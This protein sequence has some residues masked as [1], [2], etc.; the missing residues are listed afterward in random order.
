M[1][2]SIR[3]DDGTNPPATST[4]NDNSFLSTAHTLSNFDD[5]GVLAH[6]WSLVD[7]PIGSSASLSALDTA[8]TQLTPDVAG[9][10]L[11][12][13]ETYLDA[14]ATTL[15]GV[16]EQIVGV[17][18]PVPYDWLIPAAGETTQ[19]SS[20]R[21]WAQSREEAVREAHAFMNSGIPQLMGVMNQ[22]LDGADPET[23]FGGFVLDPT[24][25]PATS[26]VLRVLGSITVAGAGDGVLRLYDLGAV[27]DPPAAGILRAEVTIENAAA[28]GVIVRDAKLVPVAA[29]GVN[30]QQIETAR[31]RY[32]L[33]AELVGG[34][35][36]DEFRI[37]QGAIAVEG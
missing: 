15:D 17:R 21:G 27:G 37:L 30:V 25:F 5:T 14:S 16:D 2:A 29:P 13:L 31:K 9:S 3:I 36:G 32:E 26:L 1:T 18:L 23:L 24:G 10:Y 12:R 11:V 33:R 7:K 6:R 35:A 4:D 22:T 20:S 34:A 19:Q 8:T 28:G